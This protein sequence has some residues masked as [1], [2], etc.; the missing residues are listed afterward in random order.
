MPI[1]LKTNALSFKNGAAVFESDLLS[2][3]TYN[4]SDCVTPEM[5]GAV[6]DGVADDTAAWQAAVDYGSNVVAKKPIYKCGTIT[7]TKNITIDCSMAR[8]LCI[9]T[10]LFLCTGKKTAELSGQYS[11]TANQ[12]NYS[13]N[14]NV[15][16]N[17]TGF[18]ML[19]GTNNFEQTR[20]YY[21]GGFVCTFNNG[22]MNEIYPIDVTNGTNNNTLEIIEPITVTLRNIGGV[23]YVGSS[24]SNKNYITIVYGFGS[25]IENCFAQIDDFYTFIDLSKCINCICRNIN[26]QGETGTTETNSY[27]VAFNDSS[28]CTVRNSHLFNKYWHSITTGG[29]YLCFHNVVDNCTLLCKSGAAFVDH[30]NGINSE[31]ANSTVLGIGIGGLGIIDN[32]LVGYGGSVLMINIFPTTSPLLAGADIRNVKLLNTTN[33]GISIRANPYQSDILFYVDNIYLDNVTLNDNTKELSIAYN[34]TDSIE[35]RNSSFKIGDIIVSDCYADID[36]DISSQNVDRTNE[37]IVLRN[38][39]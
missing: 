37:H 28:F 39:S 4:I 5:F 31:V 32:C 16:A 34:F 17:Y 30:P 15:Y 36:F 11:Y 10:Q 20:S 22:V 26:V 3:E 14:D 33:V 24:A 19:K 7:V 6:G 27:L 21:K 29:T 9:D 1:Q 35:S 2:A 38:C 23:S 8:F 12:N 25:V 13:I 18:A